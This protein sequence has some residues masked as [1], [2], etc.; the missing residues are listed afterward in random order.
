M[1]RPRTDRRDF[2]KRATLLGVAGWLARV[3]RARAGDA[4]AGERVVVVGA[5]VAGLAAAGALQ[6][7]GRKV[8]VLEG[9][10]RIGGRVVTSRAWPDVPC[11]LGASWI[12]GTKKNPIARLV[13]AWGIETKATDP[14]EATVFRADGKQVP[15]A[16]VEAVDATV[17]RLLA[18]VE[19]ERAERAEG[20]DGLALGPVVARLLDE[21]GL[22]ATRRADVEQVL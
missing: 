1:G 4:G 17:K 7:A 14:D 8:V 13:E 19:E 10:D 20:G 15:P 9:R 18:A 6:T 21:A 2:L 16:E 12:Q 22:D 3:R 11:D 5:G